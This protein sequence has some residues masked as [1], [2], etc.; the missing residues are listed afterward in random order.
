MMSGI[1]VVHRGLTSLLLDVLLGTHVDGSP[2]LGIF[3]GTQGVFALF[4]CTSDF[5]DHANCGKNAPSTGKNPATM[6]FMNQA[7]FVAEHLDE[8]A[9]YVCNSAL[10]SK[11]MPT[12]LSFSPT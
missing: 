3:A 10:V 7:I 2:A 12:H 8:P 9:C 11:D 5:S 6:P 4:R 1:S